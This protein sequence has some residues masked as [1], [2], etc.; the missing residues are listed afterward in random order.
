[1]GS[2][3]YCYF[4]MGIGW[5]YIVWVNKFVLVVIGFSVV[6]WYFGIYVDVVGDVVSFVFIFDRIMDVRDR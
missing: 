6:F 3:W 4:V 1:M 2:G 5:I